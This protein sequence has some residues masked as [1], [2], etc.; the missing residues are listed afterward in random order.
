MAAQNQ[1]WV[2]IRNLVSKVVTLPAWKLADHRYERDA[3]TLWA[4]LQALPEGVAAVDRLPQLSSVA[5]HGER[6]VGV[7]TVDIR[8][9]EQV[10]QKFAFYRVLIDPEFRGKDVMTPLAEETWNA[11]EMWS[12]E[13]PSIH[14]AGV[15]SI[16]ESRHLIETYKSPISRALQL[17]LVAYTDTGLPVRIGWFKHVRLDA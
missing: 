10:R 15:A 8:P 12:I 16:R 9:F 7:V 6:L 3:S 14:L 17:M 2:R 5:Y 1:K 4:R 11:L 13:N